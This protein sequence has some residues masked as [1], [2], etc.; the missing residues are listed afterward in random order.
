MI[1][2]QEANE[3]ISRQAFSPATEKVPLLHAANAV[4]AEPVHASRDIPAFAQ[5]SMDGY[6]FRF[7]DLQHGSRL[8]V[9]A[10]IPAGSGDEIILPVGGAARIFTGAPLPEGA[11]TV[12]MQEKAT[13]KDGMLAPADGQLQPGDYVRPP[14]AE[15]RRG[16]LAMDRNA[17]LSPGAIGFLSGIGVTEVTIFSRPRIGI[18]VTGNEL[19]EP[20]R[21]L[22]RGQVYDA[23]SA[24]LLSALAQ[25][26]IRDIVVYRS[27]D[28]LDGVAGHLKAALESRDVV[29][30]T[31]GVS[32]GDHDF[33]TRAA[34]LC[35][36]I[37]LFH[38]VRQRPGKP[39][40]FGRK[41]QKPVFGLPGNPSSVLTCFYEYV[42]PLLRRSGGHP[43]ELEHLKVPLGSDYDK[44]NELT[45]FLKGLY[46][47][48]EVRLLPAQESFRLSSFAIANCL[49]CL[50]EEARLYRKGEPVDIHLLPSYR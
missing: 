27:E 21:P 36:V 24:I 17:F 4:L 40:F 47:D 26:D 13:V 3:I 14:G 48:G 19:Q 23:C 10:S 42:W 32:V 11:D 15:I 39:L 8:K 46:R 31:G 30:L 38:K 7:A 44:K 41:G 43:N 35:D 33:V 12:V 9:T 45:Q 37:P 5:S 2:V 22:L 16:E 49:I 34:A 6:A 25:M 28:S 50:G 29:M 1:S 18:I 20:G